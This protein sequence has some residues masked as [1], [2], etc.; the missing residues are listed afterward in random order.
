M[1]DDRSRLL[2]DVVGALI[3]QVPIDWR[4][5][6]ARVRAPV[7]AHLIEHL[8]TV[9]TIR[10]RS[11][12]VPVTRHAVPTVAAAIVA[13]IAVA[14]LAV[15]L[16][17]L[18]QATAGGIQVGQRLPQI[19]LALAFATGAML[20]GASRTRDGRRLFLL[21]AFVIVASTFL[22]GTLLSI[23]SRDVLAGSRGWADAIAHGV[24]LE[25]F[26]PACIWQFAVDFPRVHRFASFDIW[27]RR[28]AAA[29]WIFGFVA[30]IWNIALTYGLVPHGTFASTVFDT[31]ENIFWHII[32]MSTAPGVAAIF[33][34]SRRAPYQERAKV[35]RLA[36][37][38]A[39]GGVPFL[40]L[41]LIR[42]IIPAV[43]RWLSTTEGADRVWL[44]LVVISG[45]IASPILSTA[46]V[47][48]DR[49]FDI[50]A[51]WWRVS[52]ARSLSARRLA[53]TVERMAMACGARE[54]AFVL[55]RELRS[56]IGATRTRVMTPAADGGFFD[57]SG[58][59][60]A[61]AADS[62]LRAIVDA[63]TTV[64]LTRAG[65]MFEL[66]PVPDRDWVTMNDVELIAPLR[67]RSGEVAALVAIGPQRGGLPYTP[68]DHTFVTALAAAAGL[69]WDADRTHEDLSRAQ[70][71]F[72]CDRCGTLHDADADR[73]R[74]SGDL[75]LASLPRRLNAKF[76]VEQRIGRGGAGVVYLARDM[77]IGRDVALKTLPTLRRGISTRFVEEARTMASLRHE[78]L[79]TIYG[80]EEWRE[81]PILVVEYFSA[82]TLARKLASGPLSTTETI[83]LGMSLTDTL[84]YLHSR[85]LLHRDIKPSNIAFSASGQ[86]VLLDFGLATWV[87]PAVDRGGLAGTPA[88]LPPEAFQR[89]PVS[90]AFDLWALAVVLRECLLG[91]RQSATE[92]LEHRAPHVATI[93]ECALDRDVDRRFRT[94]ADFRRALDGAH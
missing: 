41:G 51:A 85:G 69:A 9:E 26:L 46:A 66:L 14:Q 36:R 37:A 59:L 44:D 49:P 8:R 83:Q 29:M 21:T 10:N 84:S 79:A 35:A 62:A 80:L 33:L 90:P 32:T 38:L 60:T 68:D 3:D 13:G 93:L 81:M 92:E 20:V 89:A 52:R 50:G 56:G 27:A 71:A 67:R 25:A 47:I 75:A 11:R 31:Q 53:R 24:S 43:N 91:L 61:I 39:V 18:V 15:G 77:T 45:L 63:D 19:L 86:P 88:Y 76:V 30:L 17:R 42:A 48:V 2:T 70:P 87:E 7:H 73:C 16:V 55:D 65:A 64:D 23:G 74:C 78:G 54:T 72:E 58:H 1:K 6:K 82:G 57:Q 94:A 28:A 12:G 40:A 4:A 5:L 34:R 22:R